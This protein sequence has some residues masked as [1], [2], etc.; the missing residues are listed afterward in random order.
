ML[1][2]TNCSA[3]LYIRAIS[4]D[5]CKVFASFYLEGHCESIFSLLVAVS[6]KRPVKPAI[7]L[8]NAVSGVVFWGVEECS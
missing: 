4:G 6:R 8:K 5:L 2:A 7:L 1:F 3:G